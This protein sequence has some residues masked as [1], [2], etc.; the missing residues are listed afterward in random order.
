MNG[1]IF[2]LSA[3]LSGYILASLVWLWY[4]LRENW[5]LTMRVAALEGR[6][7]YPHLLRSYLS[8]SLRF[9]RISGPLELFFPW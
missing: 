1:A 2:T 4:V 8:R 7:L 9:R 3:V 5:R 6:L